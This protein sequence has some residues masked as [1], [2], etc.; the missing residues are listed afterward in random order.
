MPQ[1]RSERGV[2]YHTLPDKV[3]KCRVA[4]DRSPYGWCDWSCA[5]E[6]VKQNPPPMN[7][8]LI[9]QRVEMSP[10]LK[11]ILSELKRYCDEERGRRAE[12]ARALGVS[13]SGLRDILDGGQEPT[14][15]Q[16]LKILE[17][18]ARRKR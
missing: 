2:G 10:E 12:V 9:P 3:T 17:I 4:P 7:E 18:L 15:S 1:E 13:I 16:T 14:G 6:V 8:I 5:D 11:A